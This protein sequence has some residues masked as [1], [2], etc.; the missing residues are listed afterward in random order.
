MEGRGVS[1]TS[2]KGTRLLVG[3]VIGFGA[4][5]LL[6]SSRG[7]DDDDG[8]DF[9]PVDEDPPASATAAEAAGLSSQLSARLWLMQRQ[10]R[11]RGD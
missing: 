3:A 7:D 4:L 1:N 10:L 9:E 2:G 8:L 5:A 6:F 11:E